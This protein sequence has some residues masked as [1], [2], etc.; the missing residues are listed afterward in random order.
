M[1]NDHTAFS[2]AYQI[3]ISRYGQ[4]GR[5]ARFLIDIF[6]VT[7]LKS[8]LLYQV[9][10]QAVSLNSGFLFR[11][12]QGFLLGYLARNFNRTRIVGQYLAFYPVLQRRYYRT[13]V[14][15]I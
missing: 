14:G 15:I 10:N 1:I 11:R 7:C 12:K 2:I 5:Y 8:Y 4:P 13:T 6:R 3:L 9:L